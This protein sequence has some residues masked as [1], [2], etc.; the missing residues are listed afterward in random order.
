M[1]MN[2]VKIKDAIVD[3]QRQRTMMDEAIKTLQQV[4]LGDKEQK[5]AAEQPRKSY[6]DDA[7]DI[8]EAAGKPVHIKDMVHLIGATRGKTLVR[9]SVESSI[10]RHIKSAH[11]PRLVKT[12][13][14][15]F[16]LPSWEPN[17]R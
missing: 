8:L 6:I 9:A 15:N 16:G 12:K 3:L 1:T 14:A 17:S 7:I 13:A 10:I 5:A 2:L 11:E 4:V